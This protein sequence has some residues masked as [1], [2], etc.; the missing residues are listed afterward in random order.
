MYNITVGLETALVV[1]LYV[2]IVVLK[3]WIEKAIGN[4]TQ[5]IG[6]L[7]SNWK[8]YR[9]FFFFSSLQCSMNRIQEFES[10]RDLKHSKCSVFVIVAVE[11]TPVEWITGT[12]F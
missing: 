1:C 10:K 5:L 3:A 9:I 4:D 11:V 6:F 2:F 7:T 8:A 12:G